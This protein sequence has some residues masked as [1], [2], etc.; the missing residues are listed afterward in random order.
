MNDLALKVENLSKVYRLYPSKLDRLRESLHP[1]RRKYHHDFFA[2]EDVSMSVRKGETVGIIGKNGSGK[3]TMLKIISGVLTPTTGRVTVNGRISALLELG[4]GFN[5]ELTGRE[6]IYFSGT[7]MGY[8]RKEMD[9]LAG[10][11][12]AF[13]DIGMFIDQ[14]VKTY[15]SGMFVRLAFAVAINVNPDILIIDEAL[16][17]GDILFQARCFRKFDEFR[18]TGK[19]VLFVTHGLD[20]ILRYCDRALVL[21]E[22]RK[23]VETSPKEAVD[24]Y[25]RLMVDCYAPEPATPEAVDATTAVE[26]DTPGTAGLL[27]ARLSV[28]PETQSYGNQSAEIE[29]F[30]LLDNAGTP[31]NK[32][33][34]FES[35]T[36]FMRVRFKEPIENPIFAFT[37]KD[38]KGLEITGTNTYFKHIDTGTCQANQ[39]VEAAFSQILNI[40]AGRYALSLGCTGFIGDSFVVYH[41]LYDAILFEVIS[42]K[43]MIGFYDLSDKV[44]V[45]QVTEK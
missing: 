20:S 34:A 21:N 9:A 32:L 29:D 27:R 26:S 15:S 31:T 39:C 18:R 5:P 6:N 33:V 11:I 25:K 23:I 13:A 30:A 44:T 37:I 12:I 36:V 17:V 42:D 40:Q 1:F 28:S 41:R 7:I 45:R 43:F 16:A 14:P 22:G 19:T 8:T 4:A 35:F 24:V 38:I 10:T 3:S 2:L